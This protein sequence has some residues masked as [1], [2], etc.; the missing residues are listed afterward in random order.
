MST[1]ACIGQHASVKRV[2]YLKAHFF[3]MPNPAGEANPSYACIMFNRI[4]V[5]I[6]IFFTV[7]VYVCIPAPEMCGPQKQAMFISLVV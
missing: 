3:L 5:P 7:P 6:H 1:Y 2:E 4:S